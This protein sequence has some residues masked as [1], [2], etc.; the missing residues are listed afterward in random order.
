MLSDAFEIKLATMRVRNDQTFQEGTHM[1]HRRSR[2]I[3][4]VFFAGLALGSAAVT[5]NADPTGELIYPGVVRFIDAGVEPAVIV[6]SMGLQREFP[7]IGDVPRN[8]AVTPEY[9]ETD[10]GKEG[11]RIAAPDGTS[12]YG[13]GEVSGPLLRNGRITETWNLD[14]YGYGDDQPNLYK[15][16]PWV[17]GVRPDGTSF[18]VYADTTYR[19]RIDLTDGIEMISDGPDFAVIVVEGATPQDVVMTFADL[20]GKIDMPPLWSLGYHQC[21][22]SY[23]PDARVREIADGFR[24]RNIPADVIW[25]DIDYMDDFRTF[26]F[27]SEHFPDPAATN[28]Y[29][30]SKGFSTIWMINPG[31]KKDPGY[32]VYD[33]GT[34][35]N[36]WVKDENGKTYVGEVWPGDC[37]FPDYTNASVREWWATLYMDFMA[38]GIDGV[39]NDMN[40]PAIFNVPTKTMPES[41][42]H[43][44]DP[45]LGGYGTHARFHNVYGMFMIKATRE[46]I[47]RAKPHKRPFV[48]SRAGHVGLQRYGATWT[49]DNTANWYHLD[50]SVPMILNMGLSAHPFTGPDIGG[51]QHNG[52]AALFERWIG[53]GAFYPFSRGHT[54]KGNIDKE[55]WAFGDE[56]ENTAR[57]ALERRYRFMPY[58]YTR[59]REAHLTGMPVMQ[60]LFFHDP[61]DPAL[62][63]EDDAFLFGADVLIVPQHSP[64][65]DK[66]VALP[67]DARTGGWLPFDF[68]DGDNEDLPRMHLRAGAIVPTGPVMQHTGEKPLDPITL[69]IA[70]DA[71]GNATGELYEDEGDG[72][73]FRDGYFLHTRYTAKRNANNVEITTEHVSGSMP[74]PERTMV[75][76]LLMP[77]GTQREATGTD[78][79]TIRISL[80]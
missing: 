34:E 29:L 13:T 21:R 2:V 49:G 72:W 68:E 58:L 48:L 70:L 26:S 51:F 75:V 4:F 12:F 18:G 35:I 62:R 76:R 61:K 5:A 77:D 38:T 19:V 52:D 17:M 80:Q 11:F 39:W 23:Y 66:I 57:Q 79:Q 41:N 59:F 28:A 32:F 78:G 14:A 31:V 42:I 46:G 56:V 50:V 25:M 7:A 63:A 44:A 1:H 16:F 55:P 9:F 10:E 37:V 24:E 3:G 64:Q 54:G 60:P 15:S 22:Y 30:H 73:R 36:A 40:E 43:R 8:W 74:R 45:E 6:P 65:R 27:S 67:A 53:V 69:L 33:Q 47:M 71:N 20:T